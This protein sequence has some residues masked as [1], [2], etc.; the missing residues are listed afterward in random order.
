MKLL[1]VGPSLISDGYQVILTDDNTKSV[2]RTVTS[3]DVP[4]AINEIVLDMMG[5]YTAS[6][7]QYAYRRFSINDANEQEIKNLY[8]MVEQQGEWVS[9]PYRTDDPASLVAMVMLVRYWQ[10]FN[11]RLLTQEEQ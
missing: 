11:R 6:D 9:I 1:M 3:D 8:Y 7:I 2:E 10:Y 4:A 5:R